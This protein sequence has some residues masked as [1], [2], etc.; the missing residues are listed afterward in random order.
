[1]RNNGTAKTTRFTQAL[2]VFAC[3]ASY[4]VVCDCG[5]ELRGP[6]MDH[7]LIELLLEI[8]DLRFRIF[9]A[10][11]VSSVLIIQAP[12]RFWKFLLRF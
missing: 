3:D 11:L 12:V 6:G 7:R 5:V 8:L 10:V 1:M 2:V 9:K 4:T